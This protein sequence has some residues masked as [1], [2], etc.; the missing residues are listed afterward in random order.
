MRKL[1]KFLKI[2]GISIFSL[3][4]LIM[5]FIGLYSQ[6][7]NSKIN[8]EIEGLGTK[9]IVYNFKSIEKGERHFKFGY[10]INDKI[11]ISA[12]VKDISRLMIRTIEKR[13]TC[14]SKDII[15][16]IEPNEKT[17]IKGRLNKLSIDYD[18]VEGSKMCQQ[19][20]ELRKNI[21]PLLEEE[22]RLWYKWWPNRNLNSKETKESAKQFHDLKFNVIAKKRIEF[23]K[24]HLDYELSPLYLLGNGI[25]EDTIVKYNGLFSSN[26]KQSSYGK[27]L[28][29]K[30]NASKNHM[31]PT[32]SKLDINEQNFEL[33]KLRG[34]YIVLDFW[35]TWCGPC[36]SGMTKMKE[37]Y[38]K[39]D[40]D[41]EFVGIACNDNES[42]WKK[43]IETNQMNWIQILNNNPDKDIASLYGISNYPTKIIIDPKGRIVAK[44]T[45]EGKDFYDKIDTIIEEI[46]T[47]NTAL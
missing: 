2:G 20:A 15:L 8:A 1:I 37:Y 25:P 22:S 33:I 44:F 35:G 47:A 42:N 14:Q 38:D 7:G 6:L 9:L 41:V 40:A 18:V 45:G 30:V 21:L 27:K 34:K 3:I 32:F 19:Y 16:F 43:T 11:R 36:L 4:A 23:A 24:Q 46:T 17:V 12:S 26:V 39:Y 31:A 10:C 13:T 5:L 29:A 28:S